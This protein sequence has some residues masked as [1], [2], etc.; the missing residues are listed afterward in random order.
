MKKEDTHMHVSRY[1]VLSGADG[2]GKTTTV[3]ILASYLSLYGFTCVHWFRGSHLFSSVLSR[4]LRGFSAFRGSCNPY[5]KICVPRRLR[6]VWIFLE[7]VSLLPHV[8]A[9]LILGRLCRFLLCDRGLLDF[10]VWIIATLGYPVFLDAV[11]GRFLLR[12]ASKEGPI[13]LYADLE[14]LAKRA[15]VP[16]SFIARE[17]AIYSILAKYITRCRINTGTQGPREVFKGVLKCLEAAN[18]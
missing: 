14:V 9:R 17:L 3:K 1:V 12:L 13:Y 2:S 6:S 18:H 4:F 11:Y 7:F 15:D 16:R 8:I 5:Y 10:I